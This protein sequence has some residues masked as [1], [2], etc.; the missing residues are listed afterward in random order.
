MQKHTL[1]QTD[2]QADSDKQTATLDK[3]TE[4]QKVADKVISDLT[5]EA[6]NAG[7]DLTKGTSQTYT[8]VEEAKKD[9]AKQE[10]ALKDAT[11][12]KANAETTNSSNKK[13]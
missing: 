6:Q 13:S 10:R 8:S 7:L 2:A 3:A 5:K 12:A 11:T 4:T 1:Q 9:I